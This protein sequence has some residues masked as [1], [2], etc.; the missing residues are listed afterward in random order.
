MWR[1]TD[2]RA[3]DTDS[4]MDSD[5][6]FRKRLKKTFVAADVQTSGTIVHA[7]L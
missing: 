5:Y 4:F 7:L 1:D 3:A 6:F 2:G